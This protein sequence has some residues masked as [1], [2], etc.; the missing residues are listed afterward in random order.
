MLPKTLSPFV[1]VSLVA[2]VAYAAPAAASAKEHPKEARERAHTTKLHVHAKGGRHVRTARHVMARLQTPEKQ[3]EAKPAAAMKLPQLPPGMSAASLGMPLEPPAEEKTSTEDKPVLPKREPLMTEGNAG[4]LP[5]HR[6]ISGKAGKH[7]SKAPCLR[8]AIE[9]QRGNEDEKFSV[10]RCDGGVAPLAVEQLSILARPGNAARPESKVADLAKNKG[11]EIAPGIARV[12]PML[13]ERLQKMV[14]HFQKKGAAAL[15]VV[16]V[17]GVRPTA[18]GS[19]H[20]SGHALDMRIEGV[21]NEALVGFCKT[22]P[23]TGCGYYP[24]SSFIHLDVRAGAGHIS[25]IDAS[26]PGEHARYVNGWPPP[27]R[28]TEVPAQAAALAK[29]ERAESEPVDDHPADPTDVPSQPES[30]LGMA[31]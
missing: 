8:D 6:P 31:R 1:L 24:N 9:F 22:L 21:P 16:L 26:G 23:D 11:H 20:A 17:S 19:L 18:K 5:A 27:D 10:T 7:A 28:K 4:V 14:D 12:D 13:L 3:S 29:L 30:A 2:G 25:W 15:K